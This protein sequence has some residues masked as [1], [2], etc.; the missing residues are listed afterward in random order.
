MQ[1]NKYTHTHER[2]RGTAVGNFGLQQQVASPRPETWRNRGININGQDR[3]EN[4]DIQRCEGAV[5]DNEQC[6]DRVE[7]VD[8]T[9]V[10]SCK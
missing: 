6:N 1:F 5:R 3:R 2:D 4:G 8:G 9:E 7:E 10:G